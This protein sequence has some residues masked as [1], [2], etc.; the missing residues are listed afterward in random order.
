MS[1]SQS[2]PST[3]TTATVEEKVK[4][5]HYSVSEA[6]EAGSGKNV[7]VTGMIASYSTP[8]K[9]I[10][11]SE[12][13]CDNPLCS[14]VGSE[15]YTP[16][17]LVPLNRLDNTRGFSIKCFK[18]GST[19]F[20]AYHIYNNTRPI[21]LEDSDKASDEAYNSTDRLEVVL[22]DD[23]ASRVIAG[24]IVDIVGDIITQRKSDSGASAKNNSKKLVNVLHSSDIRYR[25]K[26]KVVIT[27]KDIDTFY[28]H[29]RICDAVYAK[30]LE[31]SKTNKQI[32]PMRY[33]DR[34]VAMFAP[35]VLGYENVKLGL[36]RSLVGGRKDHGD[37]NGR[38][39]RINTVLVGDKGTAKSML[40]KESTKLIPNSR[41]ISAQNTSGKS[42]VG[43]V[44]K[45]NDGYY[46]R[47]GPTVLAR[48]AVCAIN[49]FG[50]M[51]LEDQGH[52]N[53]IAEEGKTTLIKYAITFELDAQTTIIAIANQFNTEWNDPKSI[54]KDE[55]PMLR[56]LIDRS[57]QVYA[58]R[59][60]RTEQ[61][62]EQYAKQ[63]TNLRK[64][65]PHNYRGLWLFIS[66][67]QC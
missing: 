23:A 11:R 34:L 8:Y 29:K 19:A 15:S 39:G 66:Y 48:N 58:F 4:K 51:P 45:E 26:D 13:K 18:C 6:I 46:L 12:W 1:S 28:R 33:I 31:A 57:D 22:Y 53:D 64:R 50:L 56:T 25:N 17:L 7:I 54:S 3:T 5:T 27:Q 9:T 35:N 62:L 10:S 24:E 60:E 40:G 20:D 36:L 65:R 16:P 55:I 52:L 67:F 61:E 47:L 44:D 14:L 63:K 49:E 41:Y 43:I 42:L 2:T 38:R 21:Q 32:V 59:D 30:E 37:D